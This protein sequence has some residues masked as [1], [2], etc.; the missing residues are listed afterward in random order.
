MRK[1]FISVI[2]ALAVISGSVS[3]VMPVATAADTAIVEYTFE[4]PRGSENVNGLEYEIY[5]GY[6]SLKYCRDCSE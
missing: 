4:E 1:S 5:K 3:G 2:A 6:A